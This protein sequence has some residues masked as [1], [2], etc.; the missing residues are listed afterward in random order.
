MELSRTRSQSRSNNNMLCGTRTTTTVGRCLLSI[1]VVVLGL[2]CLHI[3]GVMGLPE[4]D[5]DLASQF[6]DTE[7]AKIKS[8]MSLAITPDGTKMFVTQKEGY[9]HL[10]E[11]FQ[12]TTAGGSVSSRTRTVLNIFNIMCSNGERALGGVAVHPKFGTDNHWIY[13]YYTYNK[14]DDCDESVNVNTGPVN[15]F[16]RW[17]YDEDRGMVDPDSEEV[18]FD[19]PR[20]PA[21]LH[22]SGDIAF[23]KDGNIYVTVGDGGGRTIRNRAGVVYP[24]AL[25]RLFGKVI[26]LTDEGKIPSDNPYA[27]DPDG[28]VCGM[29][30]EAPSADMKCKEI[31]SRGHRNPI[32]FAMNPN[33]ADGVT[34]YYINEVG[35]A[36]WEEIS[37]GGDGYAGANYGYPERTGKCVED[38]ETNC[39]P[40]DEKDG[41]T[42]PVHWYH[43]DP[44]HGGAV[45]AGAFVPNDAGWPG[46]FQDSYI[47]ADY[48]IG[49]F[50]VMT[51][52]GKG[53]EYP[54]CK[55]PVSPYESS[56]KVLSD[57]EAVIHMA[58]GPAGMDKDT[59]RP[60]QSL[61]YV[62]RDGGHRG[63]HKIEFTGTANRGPKAN[64]V[65]DP[66]FG[67]K[68]L[69]VNFDGT[70]SVD[71]D[72][73]ELSYEWDVDGDGEVDSTSSKTSHEF[74]KAG[75][76]YAT[77]T[78]KDG[79]GAKSMTEVRIEVENTPPVPEIVNPLPGTTFGVGEPFELVGIATDGEDGA[80]DDS[81]LTWEVRQHHNTHFHPFIAAETPGNKLIIKAPEP[82]DFDASL[83]SY[84]EILLTATDSQGLSSTTSLKI[85]PRTV[86]VTIDSVPSGLEIV[87]YGDVH[88]TPKKVIT[89]ENHIFELEAYDQTVDGKTYNFASWSDGGGQMHEFEALPGSGAN[90]VV[91]ED[92]AATNVIVASFSRDGVPVRDGEVVD[93]PA[94]DVGVSIEEEVEDAILDEGELSAIDLD[95][96]GGLDFVVSDATSIT[97]ELVDFSVVIMFNDSAVR[98]RQLNEAVIVEYLDKNLRSFTATALRKEIRDMVKSLDIPYA[99]P[100]DLRL[101][102]KIRRVK[103]GQKYEVVYGGDITFKKKKDIHNLPTAV[104]IQSMQVQ[105]MDE[106]SHQVFYDLKANVPG[107]RVASVF[108]STNVPDSLNSSPSAN[109]EDGSSD[110]K[111][112]TTFIIIISCAI[113][114][115]LV[116]V[117][118]AA[119]LLVRSRRKPARKS[120]TTKTARAVDDGSLQFSKKAEQ[121]SLVGGEED[122]HSCE[123]DSVVMSTTMETDTAESPQ[124]SPAK[125]TPPDAALIS[126]ESDSAY[127]DVSVTGSASAVAPSRTRPAEQDLPHQP[128]AASDD[129]ASAYD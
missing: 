36:V 57:R 10:V 45:T 105:S 33:T 125:E 11:N 18:F 76:Y 68:P 58:F 49:G 79:S 1:V 81:A 77:L 63:V 96:G 52:G 100:S 3:Q 80:L 9:L 8:P 13:L 101:A 97:A 116:L 62:S 16:S 82:E 34:E 51:P 2:S 118:I 129:E 98:R 43:H 108:A 115:G 23:G 75:T 67:F 121:S 91:R 7:I 90:D 104:T 109:S 127:D 6:D 31:Y 83:T 38:S 70:T 65:A 117:S 22:N 88:V 72:G 124:A 30:G 73:D 111:M 46:V 37:R 24:Q 53:C 59:G 110:E 122:S 126:D 27:D 35:R 114:G 41:Y 107:A 113:A 26:R 29:D 128:E 74:N 94:K 84:L 69:V 106:I 15:R 25:D 85:Y 5:S 12:P 93:N 86:E 32:R 103:E 61:Y 120:N 42:D 112:D 87:A 60:R 4:I 71:P 95:E 99:K 66:V 47:Y 55:V 64:I 50:Y 17:T 28:Y 19:T 78:V 92:G 14:Y 20:V 56:K 54:D 89:W 39:K 44:E 40:P 21:K 48:S 102:R 119:V 123:K